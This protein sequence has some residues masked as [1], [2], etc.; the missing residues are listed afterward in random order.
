M[1]DFEDEAR[2]DNPLL[3]S[4]IDSED[5]GGSTDSLSEHSD[6]DGESLDDSLFAA[7]STRTTPLQT[8]RCNMK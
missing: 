1:S 8:H 3:A 7:E 4:V 2:D 6:E 5:E